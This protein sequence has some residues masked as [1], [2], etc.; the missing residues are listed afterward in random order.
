MNTYEIPIYEKKLSG[1]RSLVRSEVYI[2]G[3]LDSTKFYKG[4]T[5]EKI[6]YPNKKIYYYEGTYG[7][8]YL[9]LID[10]NINES[11]YY[12]N[13]KIKK[14]Y[15]EGEQN[16]ERL[17]KRIYSNNHIHFYKGD[18]GEEHLVQ[19][20]YPRISTNSPYNEYFEGPKNEER[21]TYVKR[22]EYIEYYEGEQGEE[23]LVTIKYPENLNKKRKIKHFEN[24]VHTSTTIY[25]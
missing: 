14:E 13:K 25:H 7:N 9:T 6:V 3:I 8:E 17:V 21:K 11:Y 23:R 19:I 15:F 5:L 20:Y 2:D 18:K 1:K 16:Q 24:N 4:F 10:Y 22:D 12:T